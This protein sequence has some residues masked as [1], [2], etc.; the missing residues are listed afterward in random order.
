MLAELGQFSL[1]IALSVAC[2]LATLPMI[3]AHRSDNSLMQVARPAALVQMLFVTGAFVALVLLFVQNDFTVAYVASHSNSHLPV[4]FKISAVWGG[5]EGSLLLWVFML[6]GWTGAVALFSG[7]LPQETVARTLGVM[8]WISIGFLSFVLFTSNPFDRLLPD[9]PFDGNDLNPLLQDF[10][11]II[12]PPTLYMGYVG[13]S[14]VFAF[15]IAGLLNGQLDSAWAR[16][17][18]PWTLIAW[19]FLTIGIALGSWWAY[20][21]LGWGGWWFWDPVENASLM[22]W[23]S[24]TALL[25]ALSVTEKRKVF[26][27]WTVMLAIITFSLSLLGTFLVRSGVLT[28]VHAFASDPERGLFILIFLGIVVGGSLTL[29]AMR[30]H[31]FKA[32]G[33]YT[34]FSR[35]TLIMFGNLLLVVATFAVLLG[36]LFPL[37][38]EAFGQGKLSVGPP[39]FNLIFMPLAFAALL[40]MGSAP[41]V[42]WKKQSWGGFASS[43]GGTAVISLL[44][45]FALP[46]FYSGGLNWKVVLATTFCVWLFI[47]TGKD[48]I[49]RTRSKSNLLRGLAALPNSYKGMILGH[50]GIAFIVLGVTYTSFYTNEIDSRLRQGES[51]HIENYRFE[52]QG[53]KMGKKVNYSAQIGKID[54]YK[55]E[56]FLL[57]LSPEKRVYTVQKNMMTEAAIEWNLARDLYVALGESFDDG[58]WAVRVSYKPFV[59]WIWLGA[60][61]SALGGFFVV[62]DRRYRLKRYQLDVEQSRLP[63][64]NERL[65]NP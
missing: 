61:I 51:I 54:V 14:V 49:H 26:K 59:R 47:A 34:T 3:G 37:I 48:I 45:G 52:F 19:C 53:V 21:E 25:H 43:M 9:F 28:S 60:L 30:S 41:F 35:E 27:S 64:S 57:S 31:L 12:H 50:V 39:Y 1:I 29:F 4:W 44:L 32:E 17:S 42:K 62:A 65:I 23:L 8:G 36:T 6:S 38:S 24:G 55:D 56:E 5:H 20:Y 7:G 58:S 11:L 10:G 63:S 33:R 2:L 15:A 40:L 22:P 46:W 18:R 16:W 13:F